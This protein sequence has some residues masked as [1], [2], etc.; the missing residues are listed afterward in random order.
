MDFRFI[1]A[2][3][4]HKKGKKPTAFTVLCG[5]LSLFAAFTLTVGNDTLVNFLTIIL[6]GGL[7]GMFTLGITHTFTSGQGSFKICIDF[8]KDA[9]T[10]TFSDIG[11]VFGSVKH[12]SKKNK[13]AVSSTVGVLVA[14]PVVAV[15][16]PC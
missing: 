14:L 7:Y 2:L 9:F 4:G 3:Y 6:V 15:I 12:S 10:T 13:K 16:V 11:L 8:A 1:T 5:L